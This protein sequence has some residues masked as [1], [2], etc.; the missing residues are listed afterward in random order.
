MPE[1]I[2][3]TVSLAPGS[4]LK[5]LLECALSIAQ[6]LCIIHQCCL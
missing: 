2:L 4:V 5:H 6:T 1:M 3:A